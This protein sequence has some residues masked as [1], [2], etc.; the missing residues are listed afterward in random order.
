M[1]NATVKDFSREI[2]RSIARF[3]SILL[4]VFI[5]VAFFVG[6][7]STAT[8]MKHTADIY[9]DKYNIQDIRVIST[10]GI[11][12][13]DIDAIEELSTV[14]HAQGSYFTDVVTMLNDT[15]E[16]VYRVHSLGDVDDPNNIN[17]YELLE[18]RMPQTTGECVI[19]RY[20]PGFDIPEI[21]ETIKVSSGKASS[22]IDEML[23]CDEF[24]VVGV[25]RSPY[26]MAFLKGSSDIGSGQCDFFMVVTDDNFA[27]DV[28]I[29][30]LVVLEDAADLNSFGTE[31]EKLLTK[32]QDQLDNLGSDR[33]QIRL[34]EIQDDAYAELAKSQAEYDEAKADY[35][36]Q[37]ADGQAQLDDALS[38]IA[39]GEARL[40]TER[41]NY[42][43]KIADAEQQILD[44][45]QQLEDAKKAY[46]EAEAAYKSAVGQVNELLG[47]ANQ[48]SGTVSSQQSAMEAQQRAIEQALSNPELDASTRALYERIL[49]Y[50]YQMQSYNQQYTDSIN[51]LVGSAN[52]MMAS[53]QEQLDAAEQAII[54]GEKEL[55][56]A[57]KE[58][59]QAKID[60]ELKFAEAE[61]QLADAKSEYEQALADFE[62]AK[63]EGEAKLEDAREQLIRAETE[64]ERLAEPQWYIL[65]RS[66]IYGMA[67][68]KV[69]ADQIDSIAKIFPVF[70]FLVAALVCIT[71]MTR[72]VDEQRTVIG[73]YKALGYSSIKIASKYL[74]YAALASVIGG[75]LGAVVGA[76]TFPKVM[77]SAY[78]MMYDLP[79]FYVQVQIPLM[80]FSV[81][82]GLAVTTLAAYLVCRRDLK[83]EPAQLMRPKAPKAGKPI[84]LERVAFIWNK[85]SFS[86]KVTLRNIFRYKSRFFMTVIG[87]TG[88]CAL[89][90]AGFGISDSV[91]DV[92]PNQFAQI[93][94]YDLSVKI[95]TSADDEGREEIHSIIN[96]DEYVV[97]NINVSESYGSA[98]VGN[99]EYDLTIVV[100]YCSVEE[101][102]QYVTLRDRKSHTPVTLSDDGVV[103]SEKLA[104]DNNIGIGDSLRVKNVDG[105][106][107]NVV[108]TGITE[109]YVYNY[110]YMTYDYYTATFHFDPEMNSILVEMAEDRPEEAE[111]ELGSA[112]IATGNVSS[113][114]YMSTL[115][116]IV[117]DN[118][119]T[120]DSIVYI[121]ILC[122]GVLA[123][124]VLY[125]LTNINIVERT[126]EI[127]TLKVL[128]FH[129]GEVRTYVFRENILLT[130]FGAFFGLFV[131]II[132]HRFIMMSLAQANYMFGYTI[133]ASSFILSF[134]ITM[135][136]GISVNFAMAKRLRDIPMVESLKSIE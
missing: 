16:V 44:A 120:L 85:L 51:S 20:M 78:S 131:G 104:T 89:L 92:V 75:A 95:A 30:A 25:V 36:A 12:D 54:D 8:D 79:D 72:M 31:Y 4:I 129:R 119:K 40:E 136:F 121:I 76:L 94:S 97:S 77:Y 38:Q 52:A 47:I 87:I 7:K 82:L 86:G 135:V 18:G 69:T 88:C 5:G 71:T 117:D 96:N 55:E 26:Y 57:K 112:L 67:N 10:L 130:L 91:N 46:E 102:E 62:A 70:F 118:M 63:A 128:G 9:Y 124:V 99:E 68:Y 53:A 43:E 98:I 103:I 66:T 83:N 33:S 14:K 23:C 110:A 126:R 17:N 59:E 116:D 50:S 13:A 39:A 22:D 100:P 45:E 107:K 3:L 41:E 84:L 61:A 11:T 113:A 19:G 64:I 81:F 123:F 37:I 58:L 15:N 105:L 27:L 132:L 42:D 2:K 1:K 60:A 48:L 111:S 49:S 56:D 29:E 108:V 127:A 106:T 34:A 32:A 80:I 65:D 93:M 122:A 114:S 134:L 125:N 73:T 35:D 6:V 28:Y 115:A 24:T 109:N 101:F 21:G 74:L 133:D 90:V